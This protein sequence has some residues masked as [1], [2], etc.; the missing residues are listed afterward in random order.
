[1]VLE[2]DGHACVRCGRPA[3]PGTGPYSIQHRVAR[4]VGGDN[5]LPNLILLCGSATTLCH[6]KVESRDN[7][8]DR[9]DQAAGWR[10]ESW[11]DPEREPVLIVSAGGGGIRAWLERDGGIA[12]E[13]PGE[14]VA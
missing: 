10:L 7:R 1:M 3:G 14:A 9:H 6:G 13:A 12:F 8:G 2:R 4:G 11:Q 5:S